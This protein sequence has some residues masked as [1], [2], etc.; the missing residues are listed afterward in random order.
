MALPG[1]VLSSIWDRLEARERLALDA[2]LG[3]YMSSDA[4]RTLALLAYADRQGKLNQPSESVL[5]FLFKNMGCPT[6]DLL[7]A[8]YGSAVA[9]KICRLKQ[10]MSRGV[11]GPVD[12]YPSKNECEDFHVWY[13]LCCSLGQLSPDKFDAFMGQP[14][15]VAALLCYPNH[16]ESLVKQCDPLL[17]EHIITTRAFH[18]RFT[19]NARGNPGFFMLETVDRLSAM[20]LS[21]VRWAKY[22]ELAISAGALDIAEHVLAQGYRL[23]GTRVR[24]SA[25]DPSVSGPSVSG[26]SAS[27]RTATDPTKNKAPTA[28][29]YGPGRLSSAVYVIVLTAFCVYVLKTIFFDL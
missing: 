15:L 3:T 22:L 16:C 17:L 8:K 11:Y 20:D 18:E 10:A 13:G 26:P 7:L 19:K 14:E 9:L 2:A 21:P 5:T 1:D 23:D 6:A 28:T 12:D 24:V 27:V 29:D 4:D 25:S